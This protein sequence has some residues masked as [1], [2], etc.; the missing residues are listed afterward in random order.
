MSERNNRQVIEVVPG[1]IPQAEIHPE[2]A[3]VRGALAV[4]KT[5]DAEEA[6]RTKTFERK[7]SN[8]RLWASIF[9]FYLV[10]LWVGTLVLHRRGGD[11]DWE[12]TLAWTLLFAPALS[13][14]F[15]LLTVPL[16]ILLSGNRME[17]GDYSEAFKLE[18]DGAQRLRGA[19]GSPDELRLL[20]SSVKREVDRTSDLINTITQVLIVSGV[21]LTG[22]LL[23]AGDVDYREQ[24][25]STSALAAVMICL[26]RLYGAQRLIKLRKWL[27]T[28]EQAQ[29]L[30]HDDLPPGG[31][32]STRLDTN[33]PA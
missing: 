5:L 28:I 17:R 26:V 2:P 19:V 30:G 9:S 27:A 33:A 6:S 10:A 32:S 29:A 13:L 31:E 16:L 12:L 25:A 24:G 22:A 20:G 15:T 8:K 14:I 18:I 1:D 3:G 11:I 21:L 23:A 4:L 7:V